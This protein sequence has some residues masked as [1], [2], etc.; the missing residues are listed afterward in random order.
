MTGSW[1][2]WSCC[3]GLVL[4]VL[5]GGCPSRWVCNELFF[6]FRDEDDVGRFPVAVNLEYS[7]TNSACLAVVWETRS[8]TRSIQ[9]GMLSEREEKHS[10]VSIAPDAIIANSH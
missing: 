1:S 10:T 8:L 3:S 2:G 6:D 7:A 4:S 5:P 9:G